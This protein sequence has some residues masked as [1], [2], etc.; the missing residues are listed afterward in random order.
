MTT[1]KTHTYTYE[2]TVLN[3]PNTTE[4]SSQTAREK[5]TT[6]VK[7]A[8]ADNVAAVSFETRR[9]NQFPVTV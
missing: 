1:T 2:A 5:R 8:F 6:G 4:Y 3:T 7:R 9:R